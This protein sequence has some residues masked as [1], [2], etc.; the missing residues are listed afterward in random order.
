[1][2]IQSGN[3]GRRSWCFTLNNFTAE[4]VRDLK[5]LGEDPA[6]VVL[7]VF[8]FEEAPST[9]TPHLQGI[10]TFTSSKRFATVQLLYPWH[11]TPTR[12][13]VASIIYCKKMTNFIEFD[14]R[15][16]GRRTDIHDAVALMHAEGLA[17][18]KDEF[19]DV[20]V[21]Y[22]RGLERL[23]L[24]DEPRQ[25]IGGIWRKP[26]VAWIY[27]G[28]GTG[29]SEFCYN[30][31]LDSN[32]SWWSSMGSLEWFQDYRGQA[33][34]LVDDFRKDFCKFH[35]LLRY[36]DKY[37]LNVATKGYHANWKPQLLLITS[38]FS[39]EDVYETREDIGQL[40]R[41]LTIVKEFQTP[42]DA[43]ALKLSLD[44]LMA[45]SWQW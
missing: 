31:M 33:I 39:P 13:T 1:M 41:R 38:C 5:E 22:Y 36:L 28:T 42:E 18:V 8:G 6:R 23:M 30:Y 40:L 37:P 11:I 32:K 35:Q 43:D 15:A 14:R 7:L 12:S 17:A 16:Q 19:P 2:V 34:A 24:D 4:H 44:A 26:I 45:E 3:V 10:I 20:F 29:K 25:R 27:G 21:K 9:G